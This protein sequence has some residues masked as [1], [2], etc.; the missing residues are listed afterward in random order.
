MTKTTTQGESTSSPQV[1][2]TQEV[3][4]AI[5]M[6]GGI[7]LAI[8]INGVAQELLHL[9][10][11]TAP[12]VRPDDSGIKP[13]A[14]YADKE[15][16]GSERVYRKLGQMLVRGMTTLATQ[17]SEQEGAKKPESRDIRTRFTVD[18]LS[19]SSAGGINAVFL[20]K[21]L[22]NDQPLDD[23]E[24]LWVREGDIA[25]LI[26]DNDSLKDTQLSL[27]EPPKALLNSQRIYWE[28]LDALDGMETARA[29][30]T[31]GST[32]VD[33]LDLFV[34]ATDIQGHIIKLQLADRMVT[35]RRH[36]K[37][38]HFLYESEPDPVTGK[39][40]NDF[41]ETN[42]PFLAFAARTTSAHPA[43]FEPMHL[44]GIDS[45][46]ER[47]EKYKD[48]LELRSNYQRWEEFYKEYLQA[49]DSE[50]KESAPVRDKNHE[51]RVSMFARRAFNDG[52]V[53]DN[54]PFS[55][56]IETLPKHHSSLPTVRKLLYIE[57]A[58]E[59]PIDDPNMRTP[60]FAENAWLSLS[61]LPRYEPIRE[62]LER[63]L[64][65]NRL[66]ERVEQVTRGME[67][68]IKEM[69]RTRVLGPQEFNKTDLKQM[70][71]L[72]GRGLGWASYQ[73]LRMAEVTD[74]L[75]RLIARTL[76]F[77]E[78]SDEFRAVWYIVRHWRK[79][80]Y[81][82][83][84]TKTL[85]DEQSKDPATESRFLNDFDLQWRL[86][87]LRFVMKKIDDLAC[88][89]EHGEKTLS[90]A[91]ETGDSIAPY[92]LGSTADDEANRQRLR[93]V[94]L[95]LKQSFHQSHKSLLLK[96]RLL[97]STPVSEPKTPNQEPPETTE[98]NAETLEHKIASIRDSVDK[99]GI[100]RDQLSSL[101]QRLTDKERD[102][103]LDKIIEANKTGFERLQTE[104]REL[105]YEWF[106][107]T[108]LKSQAALARKG[109]FPA[110][111][112]AIRKAIAFYLDHFDF[113][114]MIAHPI[115]Y[116]TDAGD[117][118]DY[119]EVYRVS[120]QDATSL[121]NEKTDKKQKLAGTKLA[122]FG[123]FFKTEFRTNDILW[124]RLDGAERII[125]ALLPDVKNK[126]TR[127]N[128][129]KE[130]HDAILKEVV[131][132]EDDNELI[133]ILKDLSE[134]AEV[135]ANPDSDAAPQ[136]RFSKSAERNL[137][138]IM[139]DA[140][141]KFA[142]NTFLKSQTPAQHFVEEFNANYETTRRFN[143]Q[144]V[145]TDAARASKVFGKMLEGYAELH[146]IDNKR[147]A[148]VTRLAQLFWGF[149]Q[150][151]IPGSIASLIFHHWI[152]LLYLFEFLLIFLGTLLAN[153]TAQQFGW[154]TFGITVAV[155][156]A[157]LIIGD[158]LAGKNWLRNL[159]VA[160]FL[161]I[162]LLLTVVGVITLVGVFGGDALWN[163]LT[164]VHKW[165]AQPA[166]LGWN[167]MT[168]VKAILVAFV[169]VVL[170][171]AISKDSTNHLGI[172]LLGVLTLLLGFA[173]AASL[174]HAYYLT[175]QPGH[176]LPGGLHL[177]GLAIEMVEQPSEIVNIEHT[178]PIE[179]LRN[180]VRADF[181]F[182]V[183]YTTVFLSFSYWL[184]QRKF[185]AALIVGVIAAV[186]VAATAGFDVLENFRLYTIL[187]A[188]QGPQNWM[189]RN[190][191]TA[192]ILKWSFCFATGG[193]LSL[194]FLSRKDGLVW[195][196]VGLLVVSIVGLLGLFLFLTALE[197]A[198]GLMGVVLAVIGLFI[199]VSPEKFL[200]IRR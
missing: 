83:Y 90:I 7:S 30:T 86:R 75:V 54:Q 165:Q 135:V 111:E 151:A 150:V 106:L 16:K 182:I 162:V 26:N 25:V 4:F 157:V 183:L 178:F 197:I 187:D 198:F 155:Q 126:E 139:T 88:F 168:L 199:T 50:T 181:F 141:I 21:A 156:T 43:A 185:R 193:L 110:D 149:V 52:G 39:S 93:E 119:I 35:E 33:Q 107:E 23:L 124:G 74:E 40:R 123:A 79:K 64:E 71:E 117:E 29:S 20:A 145:V 53:L 131:G 143:S 37:V 109:S 130:A 173:V 122:N 138:N 200:T 2:Y 127:D 3:R 46:L 177:P 96:Q 128:L 19:G 81:V 38:F 167:T 70:I 108:H 51:T 192:T 34:T 174:I 196:G 56:T 85:T 77:D 175:S 114:D 59:N 27:G 49:P 61:T 142:L 97:W 194:L 152:K 140:R 41:D 82:A 186:G 72:P 32:N 125:T 45:I 158:S 116:A 172:R 118:L 57:P 161:L 137:S 99:L 10:R 188:G 133:N 105:L 1:D 78:E 28:L 148:W 191:H 65:R 100:T 18:I 113:Y 76:D 104:L 121:V 58:P 44:G 69:G 89:D 180:Q 164:E 189:I 80:H 84:L 103:L 112:S 179:G 129:I 14:K 136:R 55:H 176:S 22:T 17:D 95:K 144:D 190:L 91:F 13:V 94:L 42:N 66:V 98:D 68:D 169:A 6:Y 67:D 166:P 47:H 160:L 101:L 9:V 154:L 92:P 120:P 147:I 73:R 171:R 12:L 153:P 132:V 134:S 31:V 15:L 36:R 163:I 170:G 115:L 11:S 8:Y 195:A 146:R 159:V 87:R 5:V 102:K 48:R 184:T 62:H 24:K 63:V 60:D